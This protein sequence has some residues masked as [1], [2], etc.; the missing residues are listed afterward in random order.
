MA[1]RLGRWRIACIGQGDL[2]EI[3]ALVAREK[4]GIEFL[5][6]INAVDVAAVRSEAAKIGQIDAVIVTA[7]QDPRGVLVTARE[8][9]GVGH[10]YVPALLKI[11]VETSNGELTT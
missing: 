2:A 10:V 7:L 8:V 1:A 4:V 3:A 9:F 5:G 6:V 11:H